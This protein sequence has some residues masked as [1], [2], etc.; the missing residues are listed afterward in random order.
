MKDTKKEPTPRRKNI[1]VGGA[2]FVAIILVAFIFILNFDKDPSGITVDSNNNPIVS[3]Q[4]D[5]GNSIT[6]SKVILDGRD[7]GA[8]QGNF[9]LN[10]LELGIHT[11][12][13]IWNGARYEETFYYSSGENTIT[14]QLLAPVNT[15]ISVWEKNL[16]QPISNVAVYVDGEKKGTTNNDGECYVMLAPGDHTFRL[17]GN[18]VS[19]TKIRT[20]GLTSSLIEFEVEKTETITI[21]VNDKLTLQPIEGV[22][23]YLDGLEKG[24]T[25]VYGYLEIN[26]VKYGSHQISYEYMGVLESKSISVSVDTTYFSFSISIPRTITLNFYDEETG[27]SIKEM[28]VYIDD[29]LYGRTTRDGQFYVDSI[30]PG[31]HKIGMDIPGYTGMIDE[32]INI[33]VEDSISIYID[34]PNP[35]FQIGVEGR[36]WWN[37]DELGE[38]TVSLRN[39]GEI[40]SMGTS[41]LVLVYLKND[42]STP[43]A[44]H[45]FDFPSLVPTKDGGH[46]VEQTWT[47][48]SAFVW[49]EEEIVVVAVFDS[50]SYTPHNGEIVSQIAIPDSLVTQL[51]VSAL[52]YISEHPELIGTGLS[53]LAKLVIGCIL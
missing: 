4:D 44:T 27:I 13:V 26:N 5:N 12:I 11:L 38:V 10:D 36:T 30:L 25:S 53:I 22:K 23:I 9:E 28:N 49:G 42:I 18:G 47:D 29:E 51:G 24:E 37:F 48:I 46:S 32:Y 16:N 7:L 17:T 50:W 31:L 14:V 15:L 33:D 43:I 34:V 21:Y 39:M 40:N 1:I 19:V 8:Q 6:A 41:V 2:I 3:L 35:V 45:V 52:K 20:V